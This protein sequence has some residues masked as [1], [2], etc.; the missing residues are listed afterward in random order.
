MM[1][2]FPWLFDLFRRL[3]VCGTAGVAVGV[4]TGGILMILDLIEAP[5]TLTDA[6]AL[7]IWSLMAVFA[8]L[9]L[10][11]LFLVLARRTPASVAVPALV[12]AVLVTFLTIYVSRAAGLFS[13]AWLIGILAG[14]LVGLLLCTLY[15]RA[16]RG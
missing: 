6:E 12:N 5:L 7:R 9:G 3:G 16:V 2:R 13:L 10:I 8:W 4:M 14:I 11:L 15:R 1:R